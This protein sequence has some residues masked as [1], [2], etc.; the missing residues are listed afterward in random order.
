MNI[1]VRQP[2]FTDQE[3]AALQVVLK[4]VPLRDTVLLWCALLTGLRISS[5]LQVRCRD[6]WTD[7]L[8]RRNLVLAR[9]AQK[10]GHGPKRHAV[11][12][13]IVPLCD[14]LRGKIAELL[15]ARFGG[16]TPVLHEPLFRSREGHALSRR[17]ATHRLKQIILQAGLRDRPGFGWHSARRWFA[18]TAYYRGGATVGDIVTTS[19]MLGHANLQST[20]RYV[21]DDPAAIAQAFGGVAAHLRQAAVPP[22]LPR[23]ADGGL[24]K[25]GQI[26]GVW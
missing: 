1:T 16:R 2:A 17:Q 19:S 22:A 9:S 15:F 24:A 6:V 8:V 18:R 21:G 5:L 4:D 13:R 10:G 23:V 26:I 3:I 25:E 20:L 14:D 11:R 7:G 12:S